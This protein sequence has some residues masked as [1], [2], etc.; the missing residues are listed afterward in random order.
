VQA[1]AQ[2][3]IW[4]FFRILMPLSY[5]TS[6][7]EGLAHLATGAALSFNILFNYAQCVRSDPGSPP[8]LFASAEGGEGAG[9][10]TADG[11]AVLGS[12]PGAPR[13]RWCRRCR[14]TKPPLAHHCSVCG[15][16]GRSERARVTL[17]RSRARRRAAAA[18]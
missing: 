10:E 6:T 12:A 16:V 8:D 4:V 1:H 14:N 15:C 2:G 17:P 5:D 9:P 11:A 18:C 7:P 3:V 13:P